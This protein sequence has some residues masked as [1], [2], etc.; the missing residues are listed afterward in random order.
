MIPNCS[1]L[2]TFKH[3]NNISHHDVATQVNLEDTKNVH[4][5]P[6]SQLPAVGMATLGQS[7]GN[8]YVDPSPI[9]HHV[10]SADAVEGT[11]ILHYVQ[12]LNA[13]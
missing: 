13:T 6:S 4:A 5:R 7:L 9:A 8:Y 1:V 12:I 10:V 3:K 2:C 11:I